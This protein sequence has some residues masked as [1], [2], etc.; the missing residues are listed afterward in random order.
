MYDSY[1]IDYTNSSSLPAG[2]TTYAVLPA[3][4]SSSG[5]YSSSSGQT[6]GSSAA[7]S[8]LSA[9]LANLKSRLSARG[10]S[11]ADPS[12]G[13]SSVPNSPS[14]ASSSSGSVSS[15]SAYR[16]SLLA[17]AGESGQ[18]QQ[19]SGGQSQPTY[20]SMS[21]AHEQSPSAYGSSVGGGQS[22]DNKTI[23]LAIPAKINFLTDG[24][25]SQ[26]SQQ[27][28]QQLTLLQQQPQQLGASEQQSR[29]GEQYSG[30]QQ[31]SIVQ[32]A[33]LDQSGQLAVGGGASV[34]VDSEQQQ[35]PQY[36]IVNQSPA[37]SGY[38]AS[39]QADQATQYVTANLA[40]QAPSS[41]YPSSIYSTV[42]SLKYI[43]TYQQQSQQ[44]QQIAQPIAVQPA[45]IQKLYTSTPVEHSQ[46]QV[47]TG[48]GVIAAG[49]VGPADGQMQ[50]TSARYCPDSCDPTDA[51]W[52]KYSY[53]RYK[54]CCSRSSQYDPSTQYDFPSM[55]KVSET[56][57]KYA[58]DAYYNYLYR[59]SRARRSRRNRQNY[60]SGRYSSSNRYSSAVGPSPAED[61]APTSGEHESS[62]RPASTGRGGAYEGVS[63][64]SKY[65]SRGQRAH[66]GALDGPDDQSSAVSGKYPSSTKE[67]SSYRRG[68]A[69][70]LDAPEMGAG[71][72]PI[73]SEDEQ[74]AGYLDADQGGKNPAGYGSGE[75]SVPESSGRYSAN[76]GA[77]AVAATVEEDDARAPGG[78][79]ELPAEHERESN[80][81]RGSDGQDYA[82]ESASH[83]GSTYDHEADQPETTT[84][85]YSA[86]GRRRK[87][88][89][90]KGR[91]RRGQSSKEG[92]KQ[93]KTRKIKYKQQQEPH[94]P[95]SSQQNNGT[96]YD[97]AQPGVEHQQYHNQESNHS[98]E[99]EHSSY[100]SSKNSPLSSSSSSSS[101][102]HNESDKESYGK[103]KAALNDSTV[104]NLSKTTMHLKEI[105][106]ILEK[107][108][109]QKM[110]E[111]SSMQQP[112][113]STSAPVITTT[114][115]SLYPSSLFGSQFSSSLQSSIPS[116][117]LTADL[118]MK[119]P[120]RLETPSLTSS[121]NSPNLSLSPSPYS[122]F[123]S[124]D[125]YSPLSSYAGL[126]YG[127]TSPKHVPLPQSHVQ[128]KRRPSK[129]VR[130]YN[131]FMLP[132]H[133][134]LG[135][136]SAALLQAAA[137]GKSPL[138][139]TSSYYPALQYN[140]SW[141]PRLSS[142][143]TNP[144]PYR[145][146]ANKN[147][148][149]SL[150]SGLPLSSKLASAATSG[151]LYSDESRLHGLSNY[152]PIA[153]MASSLRPS[154]AMRLKSKPF[155]FQP[156][157][158]PIYTRHTI[159]TPAEVK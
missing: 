68:R 114:F 40:P 94:S 133:Y 21:S 135:A 65:Y 126:H 138:S 25:S 100:S 48:P 103:Y 73:N 38:V 59:R 18:Q 17:A 119:S 90:L 157:V 85:K 15:S 56:S 154:T 7:Y 132:K 22:N 101:G 69:R 72:L 109:Q 6:Q 30:K 27:K 159:L 116:E 123:S 158:M 131:N 63:S 115:S 47:E 14:S 53:S 141:Y 140:P 2:E 102:D 128:R 104:A 26:S 20:L 111:T 49:A 105:L 37:T 106:S 44:Q 118:S 137:A 112:Q 93:K 58:D 151:Q 61:E 91:S 155:V 32:G 92:G 117:Y 143:V 124:S 46:A 82:P 129:N 54:A 64:Y 120:Y 134:G 8:A 13:Y 55:D 121:L 34:Q 136:S 152:D 76:S 77:A 51:R 80:S 62:H 1:E 60:S 23:V 35:Q 52:R 113:T 127:L 98:N 150:L 149:P 142:A 5:G 144:Y 107:K 67:R 3:G 145:S 156:H 43:P 146:L 70:D 96:D 10:V 28:Q 97:L 95:Q 75:F 148:Y 130:P 79:E 87:L 42:G 78:A 33:S 45:A 122:S 12:A 88:F 57:A 108:A 71:E 39:G 19:H 147:P 29:V 99:D 83:E 9:S 84:H 110:N 16:A 153:N 50:Q 74:P 66:S 41:I 11:L 89:G 31:L 86:G 4:S 24:R 125:H 139:L 36:Y 81:A